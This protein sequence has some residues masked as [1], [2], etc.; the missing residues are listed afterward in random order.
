MSKRP[1]RA[2]LMTEAAILE[3]K[4]GLRTV[5][6]DAPPGLFARV[7]VL[8]APSRSQRS[9]ESDCRRFGMAFPQGFSPLP[10]PPPFLQNRRGT[11][12]RCRRCL[13]PM[14]AVFINPPAVF[15]FRRPRCRRDFP[16]KRCAAW[17]HAL[18]APTSIPLWACS[19]SALY[20]SG[21]ARVFTSPASN[22]L[23]S[24]FG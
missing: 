20:L 13:F 15:A 8:T 4:C 18:A 17:P 2:A 10:W 24:F 23:C 1:L 5:L 3:R 22:P 16:W 7:F 21:D 6:G 11:K 9:L 12:A 14:I 19:F